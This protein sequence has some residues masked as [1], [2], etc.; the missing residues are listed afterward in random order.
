[1]QKRK[2]SNSNAPGSAKSRRQPQMEKMLMAKMQRMVEKKGVDTN[3]T[4]ASL[5][6]TT[7][8]NVDVFAVNLTDTGTNSWN[9]IGRK[10]V[11]KS[12]RIRI[13]PTIQYSIDTGVRGAAMRMVV[14]WDKQ[15]SGILPTFDTI[16]GNT[17][18]NGTESVIDIFAPIRYD[19]MDRFKILR[20]VVREINPSGP[21]N[22][23]SGGSLNNSAFGEYIDE[24]IDLKGLESI[25]SGQTSPATIADLSSGGLYVILRSQLD[26]ASG[27]VVAS[28][29]GFARLRYTD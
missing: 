1:M 26:A 14:V 4:D 7:N 11:L 21:G 13:Q 16:F 3:L 19:N 12:L 15:P 2:R 29:S 28:T 22:S 10:I 5:T 23:G 6:A 8:T 18:Q 27:D 24:Y 17:V 25:F 9:R 20:D